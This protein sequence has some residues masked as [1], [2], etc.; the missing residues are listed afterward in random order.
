[1]AL[2]LSRYTRFSSNRVSSNLFIAADEISWPACLFILKLLLK[3]IIRLEK[4]EDSRTMTSNASPHLKT[5]TGDRDDFRL[6]HYFDFI[7]GAG[8]GGYVLMIISFLTIYDSDTRLGLLLLCWD[9]LGFR[10]KRL[11]Q[12]CLT[13]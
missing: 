2:V 9:I 5:F 6:H 3:Q 10:S 12:D 7:C 8:V 11:S 1:M 4:Q 13:F